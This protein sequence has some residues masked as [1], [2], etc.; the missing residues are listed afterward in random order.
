MKDLT[1]WVDGEFYGHG[2]PEAGL[3]AHGL[4]YGTGVFEGI[5]CY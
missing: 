4:H 5:R 2:R 3:M 1:V